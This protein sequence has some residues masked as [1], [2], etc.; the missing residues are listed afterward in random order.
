MRA[1]G[2]GGRTEGWKPRLSPSEDP[3]AWSCHH[4]GHSFLK[5]QLQ[6]SWPAGGVRVAARPVLLGFGL[7]G[8]LTCSPGLFLPTVQG[9]L[10][11]PASV[12]RRL[13]LFSCW[14]VK[15]GCPR[16]GD[17][18]ESL[19]HRYWWPAIQ[20]HLAASPQQPATS[21]LPTIRR[22]GNDC[23]ALGPVVALG[24][25]VLLREGS[26]ASRSVSAMPA[27]EGALGQG[28]QQGTASSPY[29]C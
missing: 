2:P 3:Q 14:Q 4:S 12:G 20:E 16:Q 1:P 17:H 18:R 10:A 6:A 25:G 8:A 9:S 5:H 27:G 23:G 24:G 19:R 26:A 15:G 11:H 29:P 21:W 13:M 7:H 28:L 22:T